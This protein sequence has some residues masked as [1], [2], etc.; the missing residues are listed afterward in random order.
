[1]DYNVFLSKI[2]SDINADRSFINQLCIVAFGI[3]QE[4]PDEGIVIVQESAAK[5]IG[6]GRIYTCVYANIASAAVTVNI[7]PKV[8]DKVIVLFPRNYTDSM[9]LV[10]EDSVIVDSEETPVTQYSALGGIAIPISQFQEDGHKNLIQL[11]P[12][13]TFEIKMCY[14][15]DNDLN[16]L[17]ISV[18][19]VGAISIQQGIQGDDKTGITLN[20]DENGA[21]TLEQGKDDDNGVK[22]SLTEEGAF[23]AVSKASED[24]K[25]TWDSEGNY[26]IANE[27]GTV[28]FDKDGA[29]SV[30]NQSG[31]IKLDKNGKIEANFDSGQSIELTDGTN[32]I[33]MSSSGLELTDGT[34]SIKI[35]SGGI[36]I[37][38]ELKVNN[39][40][41]TVSK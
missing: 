27:K 34:N 24:N 8:G 38:G 41:L 9:F 2:L 4:I 39:T 25:I 35:S 21:I 31:S 7:T 33:K 11:T 29:F 5:N 1:M 32:S 15:E 3:I 20:I 30:E 19:E 22:L 26:S 16:H 28:S 12:E 36:E 6:L 10:D 18:S 13:N 37:T 40:N 23:E 17:V 14:D